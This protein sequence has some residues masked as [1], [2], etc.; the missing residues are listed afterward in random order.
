MI[1]WGGRCLLQSPAANTCCVPPPPPLP[2][3]GSD[4]DGEMIHSTS[5]PGFHQRVVVV[6]PFHEPSGGAG[7]YLLVPEVTCFQPLPSWE[8]LLCNPVVTGFAHLKTSSG[9]LRSWNYEIQSIF[10]PYL[11]SCTVSW[12]APAASCL[13]NAA[14]WQLHTCTPEEHLDLFLG[15]GL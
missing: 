3:S 6:K 10:S 15:Q 13:R 11:G 12:P 2:L 7:A 1:C 14:T 9:C 5:L 4:S 8:F